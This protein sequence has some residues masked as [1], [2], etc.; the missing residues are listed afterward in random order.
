[1][2]RGYRDVGYLLAPHVHEFR[3]PKATGVAWHNLVSRLQECC[4]SENAQE[5]LR[6]CGEAY[7]GLLTIIPRSQHGDF[8]A[9][10][11]E[12]LGAACANAAAPT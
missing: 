7:P 8:V 4:L 6:W 2:Q 3:P 11:I 1:M 5:V 12:G 9:G 10:M